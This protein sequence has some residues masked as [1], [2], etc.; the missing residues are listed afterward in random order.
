MRDMFSGLGRGGT[1]MLVMAGWVGLWWALAVFSGVSADF[2]PTP[3]QVGLRIVSVTQNSIGAG[4]I[5]VHIGSSLHRLLLGFAVAVVIGVPLGMLTGWVPQLDYLLTPV[6]EAFRYIPPIAWAP[7]ALLWLGAGH[8]AQALVI[9]TSTFPPIFLNTFKGVKLV[10][11]NLIRAALTLGAGTRVILTEVVL[12]S[13]LKLVVA[14]LRIGL[15]MGW[16]ALIA[17]EIVAGAGT[18][19]GLGYLI[20]IGQ[21][22][23]Q[24]DLTV[25]AMIIIGVMGFA[26]DLGLRQIERLVLR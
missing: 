3:A 4:D 8:G 25:A 18:R 11:P 26:I 21:Q 22:T 6:L 1:F 5:W 7:F 20:L 16:M 9:F 10:D 23:L 2:L 13:S 14:G 12:P 17:A 19:D 15:A 24:S